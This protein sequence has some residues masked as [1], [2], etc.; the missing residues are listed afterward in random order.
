MGA[1]VLVETMGL[2]KVYEAAA[3]LKLPKLWA[4]KQI[5][6]HLLSTF[7]KT[8]PKLKNVYYDGVVKEVKLTHKLTSKATHASPHQSTSAG[9]T[10]YCFGKPDTNKR[11]LNAYVAHCPQSLNAITLNKAFMNVFYKLALPL[12][13]SEFKLLAQ[14]HD[15][16]LI[17]FAEGK[18]HYT[19]QVKECMEIPVT[20]TGYD[21]TAR[22]FVVPAAIK[23]GK[24]GKG[25]VHWSQTE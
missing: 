22:T 20:V 25:A 24:D 14:I 2:E 21:G 16:I 17:E 8:Y 3:L 5:A 11:D 18:E 12:P 6:E 10:R 13:L 7:H 23:A 9:W 4:P 1:G 15:S 19:Q